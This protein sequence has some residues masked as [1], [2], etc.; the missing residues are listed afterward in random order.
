MG[1]NNMSIA[2]HFSANQFG[3]DK[4][5]ITAKSAYVQNPNSSVRGVTAVDADQPIN[6]PPVA[7]Q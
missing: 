7:L 2:R 1:S 5:G 6:F 3:M 4:G